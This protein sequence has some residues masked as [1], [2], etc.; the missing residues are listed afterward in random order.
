MANGILSGPAAVLENFF[1]ALMAS[2]IE[3]VKHKP[4]TYDS[5]SLLQPPLGGALT[6]K[7]LQN[8]LLNASV[9]ASAVK[10]KPS[11]YSVISEPRDLHK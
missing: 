8:S 5:L 2:Y 6:V 9:A 4:S 7:F 3:Q 11:F 10:A 1:N